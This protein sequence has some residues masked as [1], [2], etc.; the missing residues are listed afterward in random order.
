L[1]TFHAHACILGWLKGLLFSICSLA[2]RGH[3]VA[4]HLPCDVGCKG[5]KINLD[6]YKVQV[7]G[8][9]TE[10]K[11]SLHITWCCIITFGH[12]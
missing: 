5:L 4:A 10:F 2:R 6:D 1:L 7:Q 12:V 8:S 9:S 3:R 11:F